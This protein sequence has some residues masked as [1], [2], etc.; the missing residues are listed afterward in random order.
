MRE[1]LKAY[2]I[3]P[4]RYAHVPIWKT[5]GRYR[6]QMKRAY[7]ILLYN[8]RNED[9]TI[10]SVIKISLLSTTKFGCCETG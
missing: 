8:Q 7:P 3:I 10:I 2:C 4:P 6:K 5:H 1:D 9:E